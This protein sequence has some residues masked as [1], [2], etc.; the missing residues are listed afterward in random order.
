MGSY[1]Q[2]G[3]WSAIPLLGYCVIG[4]LES[5]LIAQGIAQWTGN[6]YGN[7]SFMP[8]SANN[9]NTESLYHLTRKWWFIYMPCLIY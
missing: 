8:Q 9:V 6:Q 1:T 5:M 2:P 3:F 4:I 7:A